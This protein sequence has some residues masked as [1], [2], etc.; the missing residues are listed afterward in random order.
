M[1]DRLWQNHLC[2]IFSK[3]PKSNQTIEI[4]KQLKTLVFLM[5]VAMATASC[6]L[7]N[8][9]VDTEF[10]GTLGINVEDNL[11][12]A[13]GDFPYPFNESTLL[14]PDSDE[15]EPYK[16]NI[17]GAEV[18]TITAE[19]VD[20]VPLVEVVIESGAEFVVTG[21]DDV[22]HIWTLPEDWAISEGELRVIEN[23]GTFYEDVATILEGVEEF[24]IRLRG[25]S[26]QNNVY[27][28][29]YFNVEATVT[30]SI[31]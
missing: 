1:H 11:Q 20:I 4:M 6:D 2:L 17:I 21:S 22:E 9:D 10:G 16:D 3:R 5:I 31:F 27:F 24:E 29:I 19:I 23:Q 25:N 14:N 26:S 18:G 13:S 28:E 12:K 8:I 30:G 7:L 15:L